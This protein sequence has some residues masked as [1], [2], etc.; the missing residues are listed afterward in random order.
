MVLL[1][2]LARADFDVEWTKEGTPLPPR[3]SRCVRRLNYGGK[4]AQLLFF[5]AAA[6]GDAVLCGTCAQTNTLRFTEEARVGDVHE[7]R[8][9]LL[10]SSDGGFVPE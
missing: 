8:H 1:D 4:K 5:S 9:R 3:F 6:S 2:V 7:G 10:L